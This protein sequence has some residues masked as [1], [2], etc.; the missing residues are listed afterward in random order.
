LVRNL[1]LDPTIIVIF[2]ASGDLTLRK[3]VPALYS[4]FVDDYM[5]DHF[6]I[7][8]VARTDFSTDD[9][10]N[11]L[12]TGVD[13]FS[14]RTPATDESWQAFAT[15]IQYIQADY[16]DPALYQRLL[17]IGQDWS[18]IPQ[19]IFY[20]ATPPVLFSPVITQIGQAGN[21]RGNN[22]FR[23]VIEKPFGRDLESAQ[24][25]NAELIQAFDENQIYRIDHYLGKETVQNILAFRFANAVWEPVWNRN[26]IDHIQITVAE[27]IGIGQRGGYYETAGAL[28]DMMQNHLMQLLCFMAMEPPTSFDAS[29]I[30]NKKVDVM[31]A[32][33]PI[34]EQEVPLM[35]VRGQYNTYRSE[36]A[37][38]RDS[39]TETFAAIKLFIDNWRWQGVPFYLRTG[40]CLPARVSEISLQFRPVPH[41]P[42]S[43]LNTQLFQPNR[44][45]I[46]IE[47]NQGILLRTQ[48][49]E[50]GLGMKLKPVDM[51]YT[52]GEAFQSVSPDA[53]ETLIV[54]IM[55]G[56]PGLFMRADQVEAAWSV[57]RPI[58][59]VW[60]NNVDLNFPNYQP[61]QWG[62]QDAENLIANDR[63]TWLL[64]ACL[65]THQGGAKL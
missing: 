9:F 36:P 42:F 38:S 19:R 28:R 31:H 40:K 13:R 33:R 4:L 27:Q 8:G 14:R 58:L 24:T 57:L 11:H 43:H 59:N 29:E 52:Y 32:I 30:R 41:H 37:V 2:G 62:P 51:H 10:R 49:K 5:P 54:D 7:V 39:N 6:V 55:R 20:L 35:A 61:R 64:P 48:A 60:E 12:R 3:V 65:D 46:Q 1:R 53:Y 15:N 21:F 34:S 63:R 25:L 18:T 16:K 45:V 23:I 44:L 56:D 47:P 26:F 50:P 22:Q 17:T